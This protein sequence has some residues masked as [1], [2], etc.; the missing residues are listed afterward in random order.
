MSIIIN[1]PKEVKELIKIFTDINQ[2]MKKIYCNETNFSP[3]YILTN[4]FALYYNKQA[5][6]E[7]SYYKINKLN[8]YDFKIIVDSVPFYVF[9]RDFKNEITE[10]IIDKRQINFKMGNTSHLESLLDVSYYNESI[11]KMKEFNR[12]VDSVIFKQS[13]PCENIKEIVN[14]TENI[15]FYVNL[16]DKEFIRGNIYREGFPIFINKKLINGAYYKEKK[17]KYETRVEFS[18]MT[19]QVAKTYRK[20]IFACKI[21][22]STKNGDFEHMFMV[23]KY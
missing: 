21:I 7:V 4:K 15:E 1:E 11:I 23:V 2:D 6:P 13:I 17:L 8:D 3:K 12:I 14:S 10:I 20:D 18:P 5:I 22:V 16:E 9:L 19:F